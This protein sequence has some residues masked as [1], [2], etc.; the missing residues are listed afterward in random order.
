[1]GIAVLGPVSVDGDAADL[2]PRD[3]VVLAALALRPGE[4]VGTERLADALWGERPPAT[5]VKVIQGC[6]ARLRK[7]LGA[8]AIETEHQGYRLVVPV[9]E[10]DAQRFERLVQRGRELLTLGEPERADHVIGEGLALWRGRALV[11]LE[12]W[13]PARIEATRLEELR[14]DA[15]EVRLDAA[16]RA[17]RYRDVLAELQA[18]VTEEPLR[19]RRWALLALAQYQAGRQ[20]EALRTLH[21]ARTVLARE[22]G[23]DPGPDLVALEAAILRQDPSLVAEVALPEPSATCPYQGLVPYDV[24]DAETFFG[25]DADVVACL[26]RLATVGVL[27]VVGPSGSGKSSLVRAGV[28]AALRRDGRPVAVV[29]PGAHPTDA[30]TVLPDMGPAP[31]LVVDQ[32]EEAVVLCDDAEEQSRFFAALA[33]HAERGP[34]VV[35][36]RADR[37]GE[38]SAHPGFARLVEPGLYLLGAMGEDDLRAAIEGPAHQ[39]GLLLEPGLVELL[40]QDVE[41]EPGALPLLS[42]ALR[43]TWERREG[44]T[45]TVAGYRDTGGIRG[46]VAQSAEELYE[47][48]PPDERPLV[49]DLLLRLVTPSP[50]GEPVRSRVPRRV[51]GTDPAHERLVEVLVAARLVTS[52]DGVVELAHEALARAW[53]RL[54]GWLDDD[55][56]GQRVFRHLASAADTWEAMGRPDSELYRGARLA[57]A[58]D[59]RDRAHRDLTPTEHAFLDAGQTLADTERLAVENRARHQARQ[60]RRLRALLSATAI[61]LVGSIIVGFVAVDQRERA[62]SEG[63]VATARELAA[64]ATANVG[65]DPERSILLALAAID[66]TRS[67]D[68]AAL[69]E[70]EEALHSAVSASRIEL[71]VPGVGGRLDWSPDGTRFVAEGP[72]GSGTVDLRD[73]RTGESVR[74]F[75][76]HDGDILDV[77]FNHDGTLLATTGADGTA[78]IWDVATGDELHTVQVPGYPGAFGVWGPTFSP[79]GSLFAAAWP[80]PGV[81]KILDLGTG[82][83]QEIRPVI[84]PYRTSFDPS[85]ARI[86]VSSGFN[87]VAVVADVGS[88]DPLFT[89]E[90]HLSQV[91]DVA[92]NPDGTSIATASLD[93]TARIFDGGTG[94]HRLA[95]L[96]HEGI[97]LGLDWSPDGSRLVTASGDGTARVWQVTEG[98]A[99]QM[100]TLTAQDMRKGITG[101]AFSPDGTQVMTG[102][103][104]S[105]ATTI[106]DV[107][108]FGDAEVANLPAVA[109]VVGAVAF[110]S[111]G[112][113]LVATSAG[114]SVTVWDA[115]TFTQV[116]TLGVAPGSP[117]PPTLGGSP[118]SP[119]VTSLGDVFSLDVSRD[120]R[121]VAAARYDGTVRVWDVETGADAFTVRAGP[122]FPRQTWMDV[123]WNHDGDLLAVAT[124]DGLTGRVTIVDR[125]GRQVAVLQEDYGIAVGSVAF[126]PDDEQLITTRLPTVESDPDDGQLVIWDW[127]AAEVERTI[128]TPA[129]HAVLSPTG[130]LVANDT[131]TQ[132]SLWGDTVHVWDPAS[133]RRVS[134][135]AGHSGGVLDLAFSPDGSRLAT[136]SFDGTVW[137]WDPR[138]G[139]PIEVLRGHGGAVS[140]VAFSPDGS[141]LASVGADGTVR[142]WALDLDDLVEIAENELTRTLTDQECQQYLHLRRCP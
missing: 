78:R 121:L 80:I 45:L 133:G 118:Q 85:G 81:V 137:I 128:D 120:G 110:T 88:G 96:G 63:R 123:A 6:V 89:L 105:A 48:V 129:R 39:A 126:S 23:L 40:V 37:L 69:P 117:P 26:R 33:A 104:A 95:L 13:D 131:Q 98:G 113:R 106:W 5:W 41:G 46:A 58:L 94:A 22:L 82:R 53:P 2:G 101:V 108:L 91:V 18:R 75:P 119:P 20:G 135:L 122:T 83:V 57:Q 36:L 138:S 61:F 141:Q 55:V 99:R 109:A 15:Q 19:E 42:H 124:N 71:R 64:A 86:A 92:W 73:A 79:D 7:V 62:R 4:T 84:A 90:G 9:E 134:T 100:I 67:G 8:A 10:V 27:A 70:A 132:A 140:S 59:W 139:E 116:R 54:R 29:N 65:V 68:G 34:L 97:V 51:V 87:P 3:R 43:T 35:A 47:Q 93:G 30:L 25:R 24:A 11:E 130:D 102:D 38:L 127:K 12:G 77:A 107:S 32:C 66:R 136:A 52:D 74:S 60:N 50:D 31:V 142:V 76:G 49:R 115:H 112:R 103:L 111:D 1:V 56:E 125:T 14:L 28:A 16:L 72:E 44:R 21:G 114:G 17:G